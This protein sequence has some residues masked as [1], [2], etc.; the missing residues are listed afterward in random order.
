M[1]ISMSASN[2]KL[3]VAHRRVTRTT[4]PLECLF[5]EERRRTK[6]IPHAFGEPAVMKLMF[7]ALIRANQGIPFSHLQQTC[8][9]SQ[10][11]P[12]LSE[13]PNA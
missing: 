7:A 4:K 12:S 3:P 9:G 10:T 1:A 6:I 13:N 5:E 11:L 8:D 2:L